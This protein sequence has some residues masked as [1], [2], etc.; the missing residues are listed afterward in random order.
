MHHR[1]PGPGDFE[2]GWWPTEARAGAGQYA[3]TYASPGDCPAHP[4]RDSTPPPSP[5]APIVPTSF[6]PRRKTFRPAR[7]DRG[8]T[9]NVAALT[10]LREL[11]AADRP[12]TV[13]EQQVLARWS[14]WG[15]VPGVFDERSE[16]FS[17]ARGELK[18]LL[19]EREW[20]AASKTT[21]NAHYTDAAIA[22][23]MWDVVTEAGF[24]ADR[25]P[26]RVLE[27]GC[28]AGTFIPAWPG[29]CHREGQRLFRSRA[30][31]DH[32]CDRPTPVPARR[33]PSV[34]RRHPHPALYLGLVIGNVPFS[35]VNSTIPAQRRQP[36]ATQ[37]LRL[38]SLADPPGGIVTVLT[39]HYTMDATNPAARR[40]IA[41]MADLAAAV[42]L[43]MSAHQKAAGTQVITDVLVLRRR[44]P[45]DRP[46][47][48]D[49]W[50]STGWMNTVSIGGDADRQV[51][52]NEYFATRPDRVIGEIG[53]RS[54]QFGPALDDKAAG[55]AAVALELRTRLNAELARAAGDDPTWTL[56]GPRTA[57]ST[58]H[59]VLRADAAA[60]HQ[61]RHIDA[62]DS[63]RFSI[64]IDGQEVEHQVPA[65]Q[66]RELTALL[67]LRDTTVALL[68]AESATAEDS[69]TSTVCGTRL[70]TRYDAYAK[71]WGR[72][73]ASPT[74]V[75]GRVD[76]VTGEDLLARI[77]PPQGRFKLDPHS[78]PSTHSKTSTPPPAPPA[79]P[80]HVRS[81]GRPTAPPGRGHPADAVADLPG[82]PR[83]GPPRRGRPAARPQRGGHPQRPH[84]PRVRRPDSSA[85][86]G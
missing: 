40:E 83:R 84:R 27:P 68:A 78:P 49:G 35:K 17:D 72:S 37:L 20:R 67:G 85:P 56:F 74:A 45:A 60:D 66:S 10:L 15:A 81:R 59:R 64:V 76:E 65:S 12:A 1:G 31:P 80:D 8:V 6:H 28:G 41:A 46:G 71:R 48:A 86:N 21:L 34:L 16:R 30:R 70:N 39:S 50:A 51:N 2:I 42:R 54:G 25:E 79:R 29:R 61:D 53:I 33:H 73:T 14:G 13:D 47:E 4:H 57:T 75:P 52:V 55:D 36:L 38:K 26:V 63:G 3:T 5:A 69:S 77:A 82:H 18:Q 58:F 32:R 23:T 44:D 43:P 7:R 24:G 22:Q 11:R 9:A 19:D 62:A